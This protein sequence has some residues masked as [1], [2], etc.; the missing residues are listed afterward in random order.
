MKED[1]SI[2]SIQVLQ[3]EKSSKGIQ[4]SP[5]ELGTQGRATSA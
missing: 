2:E 1:N 5:S 3:R 4:N